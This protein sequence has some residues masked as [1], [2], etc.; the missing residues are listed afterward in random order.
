MSDKPMTAEELATI[1]T[2][3]PGWNHESDAL[4]RTFSFANFAEAMAFMV[5]VAFEAEKLNHHPEWTNV[6]DE[7]K[8]RL[9][10]HH[11]GNVVTAKDVELGRIME[12]VRAAQK[13]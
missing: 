10:T 11:A 9:T 12:K 13:E 2:E 6:Y 5:R 1:L 8:V 7:V 3:L 4:T